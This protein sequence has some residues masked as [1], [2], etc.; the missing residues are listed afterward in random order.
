MPIL[1][2][3]LCA[4]LALYHDLNMMFYNGCDVMPEIIIYF[5]IL[6]NNTL[7]IIVIQLKILFFKFFYFI[8]KRERGKHT[9]V[10]ILLFL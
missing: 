6:L 9:Q 8:N 7:L 1:I 2:F 3:F 4:H 10:I 5:I